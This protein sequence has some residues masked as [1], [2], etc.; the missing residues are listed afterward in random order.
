V[1]RTRPKPT[2][3]KATK[4]ARP[5]TQKPVPA[6]VRTRN[7]QPDPSAAGTA[8]QP[9][10]KDASF[11]IVG[12]GASAG[13]LEALEEF[14]GLR[15]RADLPCLVLALSSIVHHTATAS[16]QLVLEATRE[17]TTIT[18]GVRTATDPVP[19]QRALVFAR[20]LIAL[21]DGSM[22]AGDGVQLSLPAEVSDGA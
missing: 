3:A 1:A 22:T 15:V 7:D 4:P 12:I 2:K 8:P 11:P 20:E 17:P 13:G 6:P 21:I 16:A 5:A 19:S 10:P 18:V 14:A 9:A